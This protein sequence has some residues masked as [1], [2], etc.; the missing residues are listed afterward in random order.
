MQ[1]VQLSDDFSPY[2]N[3]EALKYNIK[4][5]FIMPKRAVAK[6]KTRG[7]FA[8]VEAGCGQVPIG[9][10]R[11]AVKSQRRGDKKVFFGIDARLNLEL[12]LKQIG[13]E[14]MPKNLAFIEECVNQTLL[15][16]PTRSIDV[17]FS[18]FL[19]NS[20]AETRS[21]LD[22]R[23][24]CNRIYLK[25]A[26]RALK[27][28]GKLIMVQDM[29]AVDTIRPIVREEGLGFFRVDI[30]EEAAKNSPAEFIRKRATVAGREKIIL[31]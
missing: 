11:R 16:V 17:I 1:Q 30:S 27:P 22:P 2:Q 21:C 25:I 12:A 24:S 31:G 14:R 20:L 15:S 23:Q 4:S 6:K 29:W 18:S 8:V 10:I 13:L 5:I 3:R 28:G 9:L 26:K 7:P 19:L